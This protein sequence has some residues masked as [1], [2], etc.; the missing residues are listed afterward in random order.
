MEIWD[1]VIKEYNYDKIKNKKYTIT[2]LD[3]T[4]IELTG[5][6]V[7]DKINAGYTKFFK[8]IA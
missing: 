8:K 1:E 4:R 3:E 7:V 5:E 6:Q 2:E